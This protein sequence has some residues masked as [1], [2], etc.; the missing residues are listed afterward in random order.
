MTVNLNDVTSWIKE[1]FYRLR[2][3]ESGAFLENSSITQGRMRFIG[4]LLLIDSGGT[5]QVVGHIN[6]AGDFIWTGPWAL[7]GEGEITGNFSLTGNLDVVDDGRITVGDIEIRDGKIYVGT[8]AS[9]IVID[10]ATGRIVAGNMA[11]DP[12]VG[13]GALTYQNGAQVFTDADTIQVF[14]GNSVVQVTD[15]YARLQTGGN[16]VEINGSGVRMSLAAI[17][18]QSGTGLPAGVLFINA[19]GYLRRS[20]GS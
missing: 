3:L 13:G 16:V 20:D 8:G 7:K 12:T 10:G 17:P 6:G 11:M 1:I 9:Q 15:D 5:L 14:K 2:K 18:V 4:G 19:S